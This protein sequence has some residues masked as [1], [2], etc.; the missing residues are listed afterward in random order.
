MTGLGGI[1]N[2]GNQLTTALATGK[3]KG[4]HRG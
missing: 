4:V 1:V 2:T 3:Q